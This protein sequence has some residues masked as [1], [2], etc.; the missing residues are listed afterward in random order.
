MESSLHASR[1][2]TDLNRFAR[3]T[4]QAITSETAPIDCLVRCIAARFD[5]HCFHESATPRTLATEI[6]IHQLKTLRIL[7]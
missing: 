4:H 7:P 2:L 5:W 3:I 1:L 6:V